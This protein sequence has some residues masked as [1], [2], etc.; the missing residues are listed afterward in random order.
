MGRGNSLYLGSPWV[1]KESDS[2]TPGLKKVKGSRDASLSLVLVLANTSV[3]TLWSTVCVISH[4]I[5]EQ[6]C[7]LT[8]LKRRPSKPLPLAHTTNKGWGSLPSLGQ[9]LQV[10]MLFDTDI[11]VFINGETC[12]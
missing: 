1:S 10:L 7:K 12:Q 6:I 4:I 5:S 9:W 8:K 2:R 3:D 11:A